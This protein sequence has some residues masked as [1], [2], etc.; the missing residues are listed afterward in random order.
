MPKDKTYNGWPNYQTWNV[1]L[2]LKNDESA[3]RT[4]RKMLKGYQSII[5]RDASVREMG[6]PLRKRK[7][8]AASARNICEMCFGC[9]TPDGVKLSDSRIRWG[10][11]KEAMLEE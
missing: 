9:Q 6:I 3:Y 1:I 2:W 10:K 11:I 4:Y 7:F 5:R 8:T